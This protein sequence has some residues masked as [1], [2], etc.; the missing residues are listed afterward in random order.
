MESQ[1]LEHFSKCQ[2]HIGTII[3]AE[4]FPQARKPAYKLIIDFGPV[5]G[6]KKSSAQITH[7]YTIDNLIGLQVLCL[8]NVA[9]KQIGPFFSEVFT[10][11]VADQH[12]HTVLVTPERPAVIGTKLY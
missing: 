5:I 3:S 4:D 11:G 9:P 2:L 10:L 1:G 6:I 8:I 12:G 7:N